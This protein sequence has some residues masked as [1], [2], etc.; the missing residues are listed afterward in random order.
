MMI[1][2]TTKRLWIHRS[3]SA[4][5]DWENLLEASNLSTQEQTDYTVGIYKGDDLVATG[6][7]AGNVIKCVAVHSDYQSENFLTDIV[8]HLMDQLRSNGSNH[9][10]VYTCPKNSVY[11]KSLGFNKIV[12]TSN[13]TFMEFGHPNFEDYLSML[14][15]HKKEGNNGAVVM[16]ANPITKG[17]LHLI[18]EIA[19][20]SDY[21]YEFVLNSMM[22]SE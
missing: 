8:V 18:E 13:V 16:N 22:R 15:N 12:E 4:R 6:S 1:V 10:F 5:K 14:S 19:K 3:Q 17:H 9:Y 20:R 11:F 2:Y 21:V 7:Y